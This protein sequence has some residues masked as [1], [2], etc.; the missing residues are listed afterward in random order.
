[1]TLTEIRTLH[2]GTTKSLRLQ[3]IRKHTEE[4]LEYQQLRSFILHRFPAHWSQLPE[5]CRQFWHIHKHLSLDDDL[6]VYGYRLLIP[7]K[8]SGQ[9]LSQLHESHQCTVRT[10][11]RAHLSIYWP[12]IDNDIDNLIL[13]CQ[14]CQDCLPSNVKEP[15]IQKPRP[16]DHSKKPP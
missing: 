15:L 4:D 10:K 1:M 16:D 5:P 11:Q 12:S 8:L 3:D 6:I 7:L 2:G 14:T 13:V 9:V